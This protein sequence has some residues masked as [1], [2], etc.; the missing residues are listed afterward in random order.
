L[1]LK[2]LKIQDYCPSYSGIC[3]VFVRKFVQ[4]LKM[5]ICPKFE[6]ENLSGIWGWKFVRYLRTK[7]CPKFENENLSENCFRPKWSFVESVPESDEA[8]AEVA[9]RNAALCH[10]RVVGEEFSLEMKIFFNFEEFLFYFEAL[11]QI[12]AISRSQK[13]FRIKLTPFVNKEYKRD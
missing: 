13:R 3:V 7:I 9:V 4:N 8:V 10:A 1:T 5:K 12:H 6:D 11:F 2:Y